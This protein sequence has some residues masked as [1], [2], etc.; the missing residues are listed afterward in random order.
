MLDNFF[1]YVVV[2][3][4]DEEKFDVYFFVYVFDVQQIDVLGFIQFVGVMNLYGLFCSQVVG[5]YCCGFYWVKFFGEVVWDFLEIL[6]E[7]K[8]GFF[9]CVGRIFDV[10]EMLVSELVKKDV[11]IGVVWMISY[12]GSEE[13]VDEKV[14]VFLCKKVG[15][16]WKFWVDEKYFIDE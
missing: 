3:V 5:Y 10:V 9:I 11:K 12:E 7:F 16:K 15:V 2:I 14:V 4:L 13:K 8:F 1:F 6:K